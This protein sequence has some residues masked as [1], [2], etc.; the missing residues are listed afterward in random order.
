MI[1]RPSQEKSE[2]TKLYCKI[3]HQRTHKSQNDFR[4]TQIKTNS[5]PF[6]KQEP[7]KDRER[8]DFDT[9]VKTNTRKQNQRWKIQ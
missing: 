9:M 6:T 4:L 7:P 1:T 3:S 5:T 2:K 8:R